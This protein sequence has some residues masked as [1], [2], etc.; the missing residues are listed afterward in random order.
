[1][2]GMNVP[3]ELFDDDYLYFYEEILGDERSDADA[4]LAARLLSLSAGMR[5]LDVPCGE[6]RI[7]GRLAALGCDV[8]GVDSNERFVE[9]A[10]AR[11]PGPEYRVADM[12]ELAYDAEFHAVL[13]WFTSFG[14]FDPATNDAVL[15]AFA[16]AVRPG[17]RLLLDVY[18]PSRL[19]RLVELAGGQ[20]A[21]AVDRG[22]DLIVDRISIDDEQGRGHTER[23]LVRAGRVRKL[24]FSIELVDA[25][26]LTERLRAAGFADV[27]LFG[28]GG[29]VFDAEGPR[30]IAL[31]RRGRS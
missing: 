25:E 19:R 13:N 9:L 1:M 8:V 27:E 21:I 15:A 23:F 17:G 16:R 18:N 10:R 26:T 4:A 30:L 2:A 6:G 7:A 5:V 24:E 20:T 14:Y 29:S 28:A 31:A 11:H 22:N 12:R 3:A